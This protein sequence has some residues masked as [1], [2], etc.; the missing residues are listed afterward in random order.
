MENITQL[1]TELG[2][3]YKISGKE[4]IAPCPFHTPDKHPSWSCN[5]RNGLYNC[6]AC[7]AAGNLAN[8][9]SHIINLSYPEAVIWVN[10]RIGWAKADKWRKENEHKNYSPPYLKISE[11]DLAVF[12]DPPLNALESRD[13]TLDSC[14]YYGVKWNTDRES[15]ILP[16]REPY[17]NDLWGWQE[18]NARLFRNYPSGTRKSKTLFGLDAFT[19]DST[20]I[21][22]ESPLDV[23]RLHVAG[24]RG[25]LSSWGVQ[26][27]DFQLSL[28][29]ERTEHLVLAL[30]NDK[31]GISETARICR[32]FKHCSRI[33]VFSYP[34]SIIKDPGEMN[35]VD[36]M[37]GMAN[38]RSGIWWVNNYDKKP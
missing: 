27:S 8:L 13:L 5:T 17:T 36:I 7:G 15:W 38:A 33:D 3:D 30:D 34:D 24:I 22:V 1:L 4:A 20:A 19:D 12:T 2:I 11:A 26:V 16:I 29:H 28:I 10:S 18:K 37:L 25:G 32:E 35:E 31:P 23:V 21:L 9:V 14:R 6:F